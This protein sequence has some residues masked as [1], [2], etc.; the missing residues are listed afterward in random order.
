MKIFLFIKD[1]S[2]RLPN[3]NF[4]Q[5]GGVELYKH[6]LLKLKDFEVYV[7]TDSKKISVSVKTLTQDPFEKNINNFK[8]G[9]T[10]TAEVRKIMEYGL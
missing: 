10:Y 5:L 1:K 3:K 2:E 9:G 6:T 4:L 7:D 8:I